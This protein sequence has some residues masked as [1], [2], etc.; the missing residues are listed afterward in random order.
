MELVFV[1]GSL[2]LAYFVGS[3]RE[4]K[5]YKSIRAREAMVIDL[6][7]LTENS[8]VP[9]A[10]TSNLVTG[11]TVIAVDRFKQVL[12]SLTSIFGGRVSAY[13]S[14][15][16]RARREAVLR[17][18]ESALSQGGQGIVNLRIETSSISGVKG[19]TGASEVLAYATVLIPVSNPLG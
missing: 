10:Y 14:V 2:L 3:H 11:H 12:G 19:S 9:A 18:K 13:E 8:V 6:P 16:D 15:L 5:H 1:I 7:V 4:K 17:V